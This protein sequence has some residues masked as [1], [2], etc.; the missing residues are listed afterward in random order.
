MNKTWGGDMM[1][2]KNSLYNDIEKTEEFQKILHEYEKMLK[3]YEQDKKNHDFS[4]PKEWD[5]DFRKVMDA[6]LN[7]KA[8]QKRMRR[9]ARAACIALL[10]G[11][12]SGVFATQVKG[13]DLLEYFQNSFIQSKLSHEVQG[14]GE[15]VKLEETE[16]SDF[17]YECN[18]L[19]ELFVNIRNDR[20]VSMFYVEDV[21]AD[22][23][24][25]EA[26]YNQEFQ[27]LDITLSTESGYIYLTQDFTYDNSSLG[28]YHDRNEVCT[29]YNEILKADITIYDNIE[30]P[31]YENYCFSVNMDRCKFYFDG[32]VTLEQCKEI[33]CNIYYE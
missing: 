1:L 28:I 32:A 4:I 17:Y 9:L 29:I 27:I 22:Y 26:K 19:N 30:N 7:R 18:T 33:A 14:T 20:K 21:F 11:V 25:I 24:I 6:A 8:R 2:K 13:V 16:S 10:I 5:E 12:G 3:E 23:E 31:E 15:Q